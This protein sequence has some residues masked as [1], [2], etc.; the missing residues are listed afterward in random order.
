MTVLRLYYHS[1]EEKLPVAELDI[2]PDIIS[3]LQELGILEVTA[4]FIDI[5]NVRRLHKIMRLKNFLSVN[6]QGAA[7]IVDLLERIEQLEEE[8]ES[9][10]GK[11]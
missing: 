9:L 6:L 5:G 3:A 4:G 8:L 1:F 11:R 2:H 7:I 10:K